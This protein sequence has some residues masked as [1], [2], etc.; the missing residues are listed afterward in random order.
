MMVT[1][2]P[3]KDMSD[4]DLALTYV[5]EHL[6]PAP[7]S[8]EKCPE[9]AGSLTGAAA[10]QPA[11]EVLVLGIRGGRLDHELCAWGCLAAHPTLAITVVEDDV[12]AWTL[13]PCGRAA[14]T[15][16]AAFDEAT[17]SF[18]SL[19]ANTRVNEAHCEWNLHE[20]AMPP[21]ADLGVSNVAHAGATFSVSSGV[22]A[23][24]VPLAPS[25]LGC[26]CE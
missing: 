23:V 10:T 21:L 4:L 13:A 6:A 25:P 18:V 7:S 15:L 3:H 8:A 9:V 24:L 1:A 19:A 22:A 11:H 5:E 17:V 2:S 12:L 26:V 14:L 16:P 20:R